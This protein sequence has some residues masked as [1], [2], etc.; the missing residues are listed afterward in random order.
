MIEM[1]VISGFLGAGK[2][3]LA[4]A[5]LAH[6]VNAGEKAVYIVNEFGETETD[7]DLVRSEGFH[8]VTLP[9]GCICCTLR[10]D[11]L[12]ALR[13]VIAA[14]TPT[15]IVFETSGIFVYDQFEDILRDEYLRTRCRVRRTV[16][17]AD[18]LNIQKRVLMAGSFVGNQLKN[19]SVIVI[20]KLERF[21]GDLDGLVC[22]LKA[23][24]PSAALLARRWDEDGF[25]E[26][27]LDVGSDEDRV[28]VS[29]HGHEHFD[30]VTVDIDSVF[31]QESFERF[32]QGVLSG[33]LGEF[34]RVKGAV[35]IDGKRHLLKT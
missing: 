30:A 23:I 25:I 26:A 5:L 9:N 35:L 12:L 15:K 14:F 6:Y 20:S 7:A 19:A 2:T 4:N 11:L 33:R 31:T 16:A 18:S 10:A 3:T 22:D 8:A 13:E 17:V 27:F 29:G 24:S 28:R 1:D 32:L 21:T 34:L